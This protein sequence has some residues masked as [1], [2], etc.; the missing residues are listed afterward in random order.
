MKGE[1][2][3]VD[4]GLFSIPT[5]GELFYLNGSKCTN[6]GR[7]FFPTVRRCKK[8]AGQEIEDVKIGRR[9]KLYS[10]TNSNY[11][12]PGESYKGKIPYGLGL[13]ALSEGII[14]PARLTESDTS[15][16]N[17][18]MEVELTVEV[19]YKDNDDN[20]IICYAYKPI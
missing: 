3:P 17:V 7:Y 10:Y 14:I 18:G 12:P 5:S 1:K 15:K 6:C 4:R 16:L 11:P 8:C 9:G 19:L 20:E 2:I 13:V